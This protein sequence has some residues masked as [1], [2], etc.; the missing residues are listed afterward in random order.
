MALENMQ[1]FWP[2]NLNGKSVILTQFTKFTIM[3]LRLEMSRQ[4]SKNKINRLRDSASPHRTTC[5]FH[6]YLL[7][8]TRKK[9]IIKVFKKFLKSLFSLANLFFKK[10]FL[11]FYNLFCS[12]SFSLWRFPVKN[13]R[14]KC[15]IKIFYFWSSSN[16]VPQNVYA[17]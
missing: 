4:S 12:S 2:S 9:N 8:S 11:S 6:D 14:W 15:L 17:K 5:Y 13:V 3:L 1:I 16:P 10:T 7:L